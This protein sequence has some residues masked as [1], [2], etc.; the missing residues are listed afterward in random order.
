MRLLFCLLL[1]VSVCSCGK[2]DEENIDNATNPDGGRCRLT[3][4]F[5]GNIPMCVEYANSVS[6]GTAVD[7]CVSV[8][9]LV[10]DTTSISGY[11]FDAGKNSDCAGGSDLLGTCDDPTQSQGT[12]YYYDEG[13]EF[14]ASSAELTVLEF[15]QELG[16]RTK[17]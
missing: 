2:E 4:G 9:D 17:R 10:D 11:D 14:D 7:D 5:S 15:F 12:V 16:Q 8:K 13:G 3:I 1:L 6:N